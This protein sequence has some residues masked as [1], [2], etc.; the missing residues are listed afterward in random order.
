MMT[1]AVKV[2]LILDICY[3]IPCDKPVYLIIRGKNK[4]VGMLDDAGCL[5][6]DI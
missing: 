3:F 5:I 1:A 6:L 2:G 4:S